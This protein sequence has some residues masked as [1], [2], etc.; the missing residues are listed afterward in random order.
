VIKHNVINFLKG[1]ELNA[2][3]D[4][5]TSFPLFVGQKYATQFAHTW[6]FEPAWNNNIVPA[7][8]LFSHLYFRYYMKTTPSFNAKYTGFKQNHGPPHWHFNHRWQP[9]DHNEYLKRKG[10]AADQVRQFTPKAQIH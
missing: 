9:L 7:H 3:Y 2:V 5:Y 1:Q 6:D 10:I 8:G 4:G